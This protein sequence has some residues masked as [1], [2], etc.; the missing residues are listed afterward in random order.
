[1]SQYLRKTSGLVL[2]IAIVVQSAMGGVPQPLGAVSYVQDLAVFEDTAY[3]NEWP[4]VDPVSV[5]WRVQAT[6][7][8]NQVLAFIPSGFDPP[9][10]ADSR[11]LEIEAGAA[12]IYYL[13]DR[14][15]HPRIGCRSPSTFA[16][17]TLWPLAGRGMGTDVQAA[18]LID[19][20]HHRYPLET[21]GW[22]GVSSR[23]FY[24]ALPPVGIRSGLGGLL[25]AWHRISPWRPG[26]PSCWARIPL[27][28]QIFPLPVWAWFWLMNSATTWGWD[29]LG[30]LR[31]K[32]RFRS[33]WMLRFLIR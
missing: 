9:G 6:A 17:S 4:D 31:R 18:S 30:A 8:T 2:G 25:S 32:G 33:G 12:E 28:L 11:I 26:I 15:D 3:W 14:L 19:D 22:L 13:D 16:T 23:S 27:R 21:Y 5:P 7:N 1:M 20:L 10:M 24:A 29:I